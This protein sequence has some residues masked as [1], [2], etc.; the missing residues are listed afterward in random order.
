MHGNVES[1]GKESRLRAQCN[2]E[3]TVCQTRVPGS[4]IDSAGHPRGVLCPSGVGPGLLRAVVKTPIRRSDPFGTEDG[5]ARRRA[6]VSHHMATIVLRLQASWVKVFEMRE[7]TVVSYALQK[8]AR[9][10]PRTPCRMRC[11][12]TAIA[13]AA[14][15]A[16]L[17]IVA[18]P[19][20]VAMLSALP[21]PFQRQLLSFHASAKQNNGDRAFTT[22]ED[23]SILMQ[24]RCKA[25]AA[26]QSSA[27]RPHLDSYYLPLAR[28]PQEERVRSRASL[29]DDRSGSA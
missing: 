8:E 12:R 9:H 29:A 18:Q 25:G 15:V 17:A 19:L 2:S 26:A 5:I 20:L 10:T 24:A 27:A 6:V 1:D 21:A 22:E 14:L 23:A 13:V 16:C 28:A 7:C 3:N 4:A 11:T